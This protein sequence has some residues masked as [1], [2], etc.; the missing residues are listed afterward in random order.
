MLWT[1]PVDSA[2]LH[3]TIYLPASERAP[4]LQGVDGCAS[5]ASPCPLVFFGAWGS[6]CLPD[7][8]RRHWSGCPQGSGSL[9]TCRSVETARMRTG[10]GRGAESLDRCPPRSSAWLAG[11]SLS[12]HQL[13]MSSFN[14]N[15]EG[16]STNQLC[17][18][19]VNKHRR[20]R[21]TGGTNHPS[22]C[23]NLSLHL[24]DG[25]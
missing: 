9:C 16:S 5:R 20:S 7:P 6:E 14:L 21:K 8:G 15:K 4:F 19:E 10:R 2:H 18:L 17:I 11:M 13:E 22:S 3:Q 1:L 24:A 25:V 12:S 23:N